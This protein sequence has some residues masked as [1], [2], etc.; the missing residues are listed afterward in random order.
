LVRRNLERFRAQGKRISGLVCGTDEAGPASWG[1]ENDKSVM[2][3][4]DPAS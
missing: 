3:T 2:K 4:H 1:I